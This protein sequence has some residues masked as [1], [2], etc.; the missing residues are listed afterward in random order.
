MVKLDG[1]KIRWI[2]RQKLRGMSTDDIALVQG[3]S[4]RRVEQIWKDYRRKGSIPVL[5]KPGRPGKEPLGSKEVALILEAYDRF[6]VNA[7]T[8]ESILKHEYGMELSHNR[9]QSLLKENGRAIPQ[10]SKQRRRR[11]VRYER[12]YSMSLWHTDWKLLPDGSWCIAYMDDASRLITGYGSFQEA[13]AENAISVLE[14]AMAIYGC[15]KEI[16]TDR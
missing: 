10:P 6:R 4:H 11:W 15:P 12:E 16:L 8:L 7:L 1:R 9:I 14:K 3:I 2:V 13:T 5:K